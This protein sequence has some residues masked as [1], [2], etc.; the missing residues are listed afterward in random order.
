MRINL[1]KD[2]PKCP[3]CGTSLIGCW[4]PMP[5]CEKCGERFEFTV[6][7]ISCGAEIGYR[8]GH[9]PCPSC[10]RPDQR[11]EFARK[12]CIVSPGPLL[13]VVVILMVGLLSLFL[14][15]RVL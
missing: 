1:T 2:K 10:G 12:G 5:K 9:K 14:L 8:E 13:L 15:K 6:S 4:G 11:P 3:K 7:C